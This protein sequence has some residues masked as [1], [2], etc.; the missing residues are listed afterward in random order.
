MCGLAG[1]IRF[2]YVEDKKEKLI[3]DEK[4]ISFFMK[5]RGPDFYD[6]SL[7]KDFIFLHSRLKI[8]DLSDKG[9][10]PWKLNNGNILIFNGEIF[11]H[12][13]LLSFHKRE[14]NCDTEA[15]AYFQ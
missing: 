2:G 4:K 3:N 12:N 15:L 11:N 5:R 10:Q 9:N 14:T 6:Y 7:E 13:N 8:T 1:V